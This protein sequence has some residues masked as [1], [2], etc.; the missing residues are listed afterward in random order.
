M[1]HNLSLERRRKLETDAGVDRLRPFLV[2]GWRIDGRK[3]AFVEIGTVLGARQRR[4]SVT[5]RCATSEC[6]RRVEVDLDAA[7]AAGHADRPA[8]ELPRLLACAHWGTCRLTMVAMT[9][10]D[11]VPLVGLVGSGALV[12]IACTRC[13]SR[14]VLPPPAVIAR[15]VTAG[16]GDASCGV[17]EVGRRVRGPCRK[18]GGRSFA[19]SV[20]W[21][22]SQP[23]P[24]S[25]KPPP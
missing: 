19:S 2:P 6:R 13:E 18:C 22:P 10:P 14:A 21:A 24:R 4:Q 7:I 20:V 23:S 9:Y 1:G 5:L 17:L 11:G 3:L 8:A 12:G 16:V 15:L 25:T